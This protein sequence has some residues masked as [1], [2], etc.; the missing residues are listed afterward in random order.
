MNNEFEQAQQSY[1]NLP[2]AVLDLPFS[3]GVLGQLQLHNN[4]IT[5]A[6]VNLKSAYQATPSSRNARLVMFAYYKLNQKEKGQ[7]FLRNHVKNHPQDQASLMQLANEQLQRSTEQALSSYQKA[8]KLNPNNGVAQNNLAFLYMQQNKLELALKHAQQALKV[9][10]KDEN[11]L[12]T[13]GQI[14]FLK[15]D[16]KMALDYLSKAAA[17]DNVSGKKIADEIYVNYIK[18]LLLNGKTTLAERKIAQR[19]ITNNKS[20]VILASLKEKFKLKN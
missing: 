14:Y 11:V 5:S 4:N 16:A 18:A 13:L 1:D 9:M 3:K 10:P 12:D 15:Q 7:L 20:Q 19:K 17:I 6:L 8:I 2:K